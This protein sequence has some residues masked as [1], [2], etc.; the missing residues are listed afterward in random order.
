MIFSRLA[1]VAA[2]GLFVSSAVF[3]A[4]ATR[5]KPTRPSL[6]DASSGAYK[7]AIITDAATG[8]VLYEDHADIVS[9]PASMTKLMTFAV[10]HDKLKQGAITLQTPVRITDADSKIGGSQVFLD[11]RETFPVE[12]LLYAMMI[13]SA[14][15]AAYALARF[16]GGSAPAFV[17]LMNA[18]ARE[19]GMTHTTFRSPHGLPP[20]TRK[21]S[22]GDLTTPR[23]YSLLARYL[24]RE[25]DVLKYTSIRTRTFG[26]GVRATPTEMTN[27]DHLIGQVPGVDGLKTGFTNAAGFCLT[28]TAQRNGR[29]VIVV[30]M[31]SPD[32]KTRDL[33]M[34]ELIERGFAAL[35]PAPAVPEIGPGAAEPSPVTPAATTSTTTT[36][37]STATTAAKS[38]DDSETTI[39][40]SPPAKKPAGK[41][42]TSH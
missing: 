40:F 36:T 22:D 39:K 10:L 9:P 1:R 25:T 28:T 4:A 42:T 8:D 7:G 2:L 33:K 35:P 41:T 26:A 3:S 32:S 5:A 23:D 19:L 31:G 18:K 6:G 17:E 21:I 11:P 24:I 12:E 34:A 20:S 30:L 15:D 29:R 14:N 37:P 38:T 13:H 16:S 27:S